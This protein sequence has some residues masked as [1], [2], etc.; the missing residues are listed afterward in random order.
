MSLQ[1]TICLLICFA[2]ADVF[3]E[4]CKPDIL[5]G[6]SSSILLSIL[7]CI[8]S[9]ISLAI[10]L[11]ILLGISSSIS[12]DI[13]LSISLSIPLSIS[14]IKLAFARTGGF[15]GVS[16]WYAKSRIESLRSL[17]PGGSGGCPPDMPNLR[18]KACVC[19]WDWGV[20]FTEHSTGHSTRY[21]TR[22][23]IKHSVLNILLS[24]LLSIPTGVPLSKICM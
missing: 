10:S 11:S 22:Y 9:N 2:A 4:S 15:R 6:I 12:P 20:D 7:L 23:F 3:V 5:Q 19:S 1:C 18:Y 8:S 21:S 24:I 13:S 14:D 17:G 16:P